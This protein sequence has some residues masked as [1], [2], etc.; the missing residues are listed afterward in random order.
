MKAFNTFF[1]KTTLW[2]VFILG[3]AFTGGFSFLSFEL[4]S[5]PEANFNTITNLK[6][7]STMGI[8]F[9]L[10]VTLM[11]SMSR[12]SQ[13]FWDYAKEVEALIDKTETKDELSSIWEN[14][15]Q[16]LRMLA[17]GGAH[18]PELTRQYTIMQTKNNYA[19]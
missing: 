7:G 16:T 12:K 6:I 14:E 9:G 17:Q 5:M 3:W 18:L 2:K 1:D 4:F 19:K 11:I 15:F 8:P 13:K 10:L